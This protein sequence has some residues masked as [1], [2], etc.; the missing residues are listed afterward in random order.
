M[1]SKVCITFRALEMPLILSCDEQHIQ[2][3]NEKE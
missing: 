2:L 1:L 3:Q